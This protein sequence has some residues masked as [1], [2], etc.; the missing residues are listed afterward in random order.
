MKNVKDEMIKVR[1]AKV[2]KDGLIAVAERL[3]VPVSQ[4]VREAVKTQ[5]AKMTWIL[6]NQMPEIGAEVETLLAK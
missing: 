3:D 4:I 5:V 1:L 2:D 6:N